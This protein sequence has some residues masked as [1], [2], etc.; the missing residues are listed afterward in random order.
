[1]SGGFLPCL[2]ML[3]SVARVLEAEIRDGLAGSILCQSV[4]L[5][6]HT[7][8][9]I[10]ASMNGTELI[11]QRVK[12][13]RL[14]LSLTQRALA[15]RVGVGTPHI[16]KIEA[17]RENPSEELLKK[18]AEV[19]DCDFDELLLVAG[20]VPPDLMERFASDP[21]GSLEFLRQWK[22]PKV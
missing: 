15:E 8:L 7:I 5:R 17:G 3:P 18:I 2:W 22:A 9:L 10:I 16:S 4:Q 19:L 21:R 14:S 12:R 6:R 13:E 1:M 20:R 11:G